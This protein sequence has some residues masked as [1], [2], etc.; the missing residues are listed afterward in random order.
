MKL[1]KLLVATCVVLMISMILGIGVY[2][3]M[4]VMVGKDATV[5][6]SVITSHTVDGWYDST[7][8]IRVVPGQT[9]PKGAM[10]DVYWG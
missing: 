3:C 4:D 7:L 8:N 6:G 9:F 5:D 1:K 10:A 2:A